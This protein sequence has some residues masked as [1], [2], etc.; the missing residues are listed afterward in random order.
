MD[1]SGREERV[2]WMEGGRV[3]GRVVCIFVGM[4]YIRI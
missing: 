3:G 2:E 1:A 4:S